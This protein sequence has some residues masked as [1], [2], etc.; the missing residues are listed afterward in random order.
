M[1]HRKRLNAISVGSPNAWHCFQMLLPG[2]DEARSSVQA[3]TYQ[4]GLSTVCSSVG[5]KVQRSLVHQVSNGWTIESPRE[6]AA[7]PYTHPRKATAGNPTS[8]RMVR[9]AYT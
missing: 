5:V 2:Q 1:L 7:S 4:K 9:D 6:L 8:D 3:I